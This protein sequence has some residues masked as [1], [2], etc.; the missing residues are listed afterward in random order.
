[1]AEAAEDIA[2]DMTEAITKKEGASAAKA[3][4]QKITDASNK[5]YDFLKENP[6]TAIAGASIGLYMIDHNIADPATAV[7][8]M[9]KDVG[10]GV[11]GGL[12]DILGSLKKYI[13]IIIAI[14]VLILIFI[15]L[16]NLI[17]K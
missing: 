5:V 16:F 6:K 9:A 4:A 11:G 7:A 10:S 1:M 17:K 2:K 12:D 3:V 14:P 15:L 8:D 13:W